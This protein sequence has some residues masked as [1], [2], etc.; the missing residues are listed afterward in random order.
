[1]TK[2]FDFHYL[3]LNKKLLPLLVG[4]VFHVTAKSSLESILKDGVIKSNKDGVFAYSFPQSD[5][6]Y[7]IKRGYICLF[8]LRKANK[9]Q[10]ED[11]LCKYYFLNPPRF[12]NLP[13]FLI[14]S[15]KIYKELIDTSIAKA[16]VGFKEMWI[17]YVGCWYPCDLKIEYIDEIIEVN[18]DRTLPDVP[19]EIRKSM[20]KG[21]KKADEAWERRQKIIEEMGKGFSS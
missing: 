4:K 10:I 21:K 12:D 20:E 14:I 1:M 3:D 6:S 11:A 8:D 7:G 19:D 17:P 2:R 15:S 16:D 9:E 5:K 18:V 13:C